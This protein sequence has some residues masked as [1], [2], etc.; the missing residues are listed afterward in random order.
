MLRVN[1]LMSDALEVVSPDAKHYAA[2]PW[3]Y[4]I[5]SIGPMLE[6]ESLKKSCSRHNGAVRTE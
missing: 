5:L 4:S 1:N 3:N 6:S 2:N